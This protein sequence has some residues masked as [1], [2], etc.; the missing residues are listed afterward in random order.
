[1]GPVST[2]YRLLLL[3]VTAECA[4]LSHWNFLDEAWSP[5]ILPSVPYV[6][7]LPP[8]T[9]ARTRQALKLGLPPVRIL[10]RR[11]RNSHFPPFPLF[12]SVKSLR[13]RF[14]GKGRTLDGPIES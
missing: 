13:S 6:L 2:R 12:A 14:R 1:M 5:S 11:N 8:K 10:T 9:G 7:F 3:S 4:M